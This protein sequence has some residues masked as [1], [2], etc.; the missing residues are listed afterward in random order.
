MSCH[1]ARVL[2][3]AHEREQLAADEIGAHSLLPVM[4]PTASA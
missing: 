2:E 1:R 4:S 3:P